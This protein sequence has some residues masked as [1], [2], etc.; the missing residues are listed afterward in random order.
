MKLK[1]IMSILTIALTIAIGTVTFGQSVYAAEILT[2]TDNTKIV[3]SETKIGSDTQI[4]KENLKEVLKYVGL[5][6]SNYIQTDNIDKK[7]KKIQTVG[8]LQKAI[9]NAKMPSK[10]TAVNKNKMNGKTN[11]GGSSTT[12]N[13]MTI[14]STNSSY[15]GSIGL[16]SDVTVGDAF[17][18]TRSCSG[19][20]S[21]YYQQWTGVSG[22]SASV[23]SA[24]TTAFIYKIAPGA[25][26]RAT[27][28]P[29]EITMR[30]YITV[31]KYVA[32][33]SG[34]TCVGYQGVQGTD[35]YDASDYYDE[36]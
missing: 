30:S 1:K 16:S 3:Q 33:E 22:V 31:N 34:I 26:L 29:T 28:T 5:D 11:I 12:A 20:Y 9:E 35:T 23:D 13:N 36:M 25:S 15:G 10:V 4:T 8:E 32:I 6:S 24:G 19:Q 17:T 2:G 14:A 7:V 27:W 21:S 18:L